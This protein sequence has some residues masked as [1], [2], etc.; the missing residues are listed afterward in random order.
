[1]ASCLL[2]AFPVPGHANGTGCDL[3]PT[4]DIEQLTGLSLSDAKATRLNNCNGPCDSSDGWECEYDA[5]DGSS[6]RLFIDVY[7]PPFTQRDPLALWRVEQGG[8]RDAGRE[9]AAVDVAGVGT[10]AV[11]TYKTVLQ[12]DA[13]ILFAADGQRLHL[14][15]STVNIAQE[16][17]LKDAKAIATLVLSR[18]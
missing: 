9:V 4:A 8:R 18:F 13:G 10:V 15:V 6:A 14:E 3:L 2:A 12:Q 11:W 16:P 5:T 7:F 17:G 1:M